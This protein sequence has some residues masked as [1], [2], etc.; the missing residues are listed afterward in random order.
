MKHEVCLVL[1]RQQLQ[2]NPLISAKRNRWSVAYVK[3]TLIALFTSAK[4]RG[5]VTAG[6]YVLLNN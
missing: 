6:G 3:A 5:Y 2:Y 1:F 4:G